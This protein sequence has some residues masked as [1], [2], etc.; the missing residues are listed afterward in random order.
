MKYILFLFLLVSIGKVC[1][2]EAIP[3]LIFKNSGNA[4][5]YCENGKPC[6]YLNGR[7]VQNEFVKDSS[8]SYVYILIAIILALSVLG[9]IIKGI[10]YFMQ[11][12]S[13]TIVRA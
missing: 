1:A 4:I 6:L 9:I 3:C 12:K 8:I 5:G 11:N 2:N 10:G 13:I 7:I